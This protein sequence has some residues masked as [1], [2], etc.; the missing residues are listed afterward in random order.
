MNPQ[1]EAHERFCKS[2]GDMAKENEQ[3]KER[4]KRLES[5]SSDPHA[6]WANW[7]RGSVTLP[8]GI[9]DVREYQ[10]RIKMLE[11][12]QLQEEHLSEIERENKRLKEQNKRQNELIDSL[13]EMYSKEAK[14]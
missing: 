5:V 11:N 10:E 12:L 9:G 13:R 1:Y 14:P 8:E 3:L 2:I 6:L 4:I 7:L